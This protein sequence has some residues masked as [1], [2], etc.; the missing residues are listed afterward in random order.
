MEIK[1]LKPLD[2]IGAIYNV[3]DKLVEAQGRMKCGYIWTLTTLADG[4]RND[5]LIMSEQ[6]K[7]FQNGIEIEAVSSERGEADE[8]CEAGR[9]A[10]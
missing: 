6:L 10:D 7:E 3:L 1:D 2:K 4:L 5:V 9:P 8:Q